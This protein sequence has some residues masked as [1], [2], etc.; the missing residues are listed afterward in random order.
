MLRKKKT[1]Y[2]IF[3]SRAVAFSVGF[4]VLPFLFFV[5]NTT[6]TLV[7]NPSS[8]SEGVAI[9]YS[10]IIGGAYYFLSKEKVVVFSGGFFNDFSLFVFGV[11]VFV[12]FFLAQEEILL[13][14]QSSPL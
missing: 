7:S 14:I 11:L 13:F 8:I 9:V 6:V 3:I 1:L 12:I 5:I 4:V 2:D 10:F